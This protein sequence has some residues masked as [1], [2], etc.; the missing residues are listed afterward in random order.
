MELTANVIVVLRPDSPLAAILATH[1]TLHQADKET[2]CLSLSCA[3]LRD[4][5]PG[6]LEAWVESRIVKAPFRLQ[7]PLSEILLISDAPDSG[8]PPIGFLQAG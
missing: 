5:R 4:G 3:D 7:I 2:P 8:Q 1:G 6:F